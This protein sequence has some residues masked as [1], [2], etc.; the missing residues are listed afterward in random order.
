MNNARVLASIILL[1]LAM[2]ERIMATS[3]I[4]WSGPQD[5]RMGPGST[6]DWLPAF[7]TLALDINSDGLNDLTFGYDQNFTVQTQPGTALVMDHPS[8]SVYDT[9]PLAA[10]TQIGAIPANS[11]EWNSG[12]DDLVTWM[13]IPDFGLVGAGRWAFTTN[14]FIGVSLTAADG[15]HYGWVQ[16]TSYPDMRAH[17]HSWAYESQPGV[18]IIAGVVPEPSTIKLAI[19]GVFLIGL[20]VW[21]KRAARTQNAADIQP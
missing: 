10:G 6:S 16:V 2:T 7:F 19:L 9:I 1:F 15:V 18:G 20:T 11:A 3:A 13:S 17:I 14:A 21:R 12:T 4:V 8:P 5:V